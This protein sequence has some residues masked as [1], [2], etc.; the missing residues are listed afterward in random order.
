MPDLSAIP[1][2]RDQPY[3]SAELAAE[4]TEIQP[5]DTVPGT[6]LLWPA[7]RRGQFYNIDKLPPTNAHYRLTANPP[8]PKAPV[9]VVLFLGGSLIFGPGVPDDSTVPSILSRR[10]NADDRDH[11]YIVLNAGVEGR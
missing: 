2:F 7:L 4:Y 8:D 5:F 6:D 1:A 3:A 9:R 11:G 10:L